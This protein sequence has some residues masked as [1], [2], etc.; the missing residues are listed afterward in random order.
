M[1]TYIKLMKPCSDFV[2]GYASKTIAVSGKNG[3]FA[4]KKLL[5]VDFLNPS[6]ESIDELYNSLPDSAKKEWDDF[7]SRYDG[8]LKVYNS[9][10]VR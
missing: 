1:K 6:K 2:S 8:E 9:Y 10:G 4:N 7:C 3:D 5:S